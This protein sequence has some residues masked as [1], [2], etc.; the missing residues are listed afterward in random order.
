MA[1]FKKTRKPIAAPDKASRVPEGLWVKCPTCGRVIY[2]KERQSKL[3]VCSQCAHHLR[4][5]ATDRLKT[6]FDDETW[7]EHD[8]GLRSTDP[9][10]FTD[11]KKYRDRLAAAIKAGGTRDAVIAGSGTL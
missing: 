8:A 5:N 6:L 1:W 7:T 9:L 2:N 4:I 11:T 3:Q 10:K